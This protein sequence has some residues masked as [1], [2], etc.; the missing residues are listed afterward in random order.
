MDK[1]SKDNIESI[2]HTDCEDV[3]AFLGFHEQENGAPVVRA[4][5][6]SADKVEVLDYQT[7]K[8]VATLEER[9]KAGFFSGDVSVLSERRY[10]L[11]VTYGKDTHIQEDPYRFG[12]SLNPDDFYLFSEGTHERA[13]DF[14]GAHLVE[15]EG[16]SGCRFTVWAPNAK[17]VSVVGDFIF[18]M[19][20]SI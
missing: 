10:L 18:G 5:L 11:G 17:R 1:I 8:P 7:K 12:S 19:V 3:F 20:A 2:V 14:M 4:F 13:Y 9:H 6:P 16:V 15:Q